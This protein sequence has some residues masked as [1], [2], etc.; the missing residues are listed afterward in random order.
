MESIGGNSGAFLF[1]FKQIIKKEVLKES[2]GLI[3]S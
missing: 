2:A 1:Y 3:S